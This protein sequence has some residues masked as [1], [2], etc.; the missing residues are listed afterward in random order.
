[1]DMYV[2]I[3]VKLNYLEE[4]LSKSV[5]YIFGSMYWIIVRKGKCV[6]LVLWRGGEMKTLLKV[7]LYHDIDVKPNGRKFCSCLRNAVNLSAKL[8]CNFN[9]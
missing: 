5:V 8:V 1:M 2:H 3:P 6:L 7:S 4:F 9:E